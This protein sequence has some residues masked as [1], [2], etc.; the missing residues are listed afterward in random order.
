MNRIVTRGLGY[1]HKLITRGFAGLLSPVI[2]GGG[3]VVAINPTGGFVVAAGTRGG[4]MAL[5]N[6]GGVAVGLELTGGQ[7]AAINGAKGRLED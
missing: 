2:H 6:T 4:A 7:V 5:L 1:L 3:S